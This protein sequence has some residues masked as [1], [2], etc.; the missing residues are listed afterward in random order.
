MKIDVANNIKAVELLK[1]EILQNVTD[2]FGDISAEADS[3]TGKNI[4][5]DAARLICQTYLLCSRLGV[6]FDEIQSDMTDML[7]GGIEQKHILERRFGDL[8][9]LLDSISGEREYYEKYQG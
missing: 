8:S 4:S 3:E 2:L 1:V 5:Q 9:A 7:R 6:S